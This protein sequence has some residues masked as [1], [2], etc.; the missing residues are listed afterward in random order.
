M[1]I[2]EFGTLQMV[3]TN[4]QHF[5]NGRIVPVA[6]RLNLAETVE[7]VNGVSSFS[8]A[9]SLTRATNSSNKPVSFKDYLME[10]MSSV[11]AQQ[12][13]VNKLQEKLITNPDEVDV[14]DVT[15]A[16]SKARMSLNLA[17]TVIDRLVTDWN[18]ITTTR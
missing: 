2:A 6:S 4:E 18:E 14:H 17:Q 16:M 15:I 5:G 1:K 10:A 9:S 3:R 13:D 11:N 8:E 7:P 12:L